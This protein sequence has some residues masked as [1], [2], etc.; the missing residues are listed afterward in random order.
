VVLTGLDIADGERAPDRRARQPGSTNREIAQ[1]LFI[2]DRTVEGHLTS[3]SG[4]C[5]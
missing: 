3:V 4:S 1:Q 5:G 2:T